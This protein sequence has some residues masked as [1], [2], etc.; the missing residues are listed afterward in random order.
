MKDFKS[1]IS[2][3]VRD[4][5]S[6]LRLMD[7]NTNSQLEQI[8]N[9]KKEIYAQLY[10][11]NLSHTNK[12]QLMNES[13]VEKFED[14]DKL[15]SKFQENILNENSKFTDYIADQLENHQ[16]NNKKIFDY[17]SNEMMIVKEKVR[18]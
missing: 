11:N 18:A 15:I 13:L 14:Y 16:K 7:V 2:N 12:F 1:K 9:T 17:M 4:T 5:E 6:K 3:I 10:D 8:E